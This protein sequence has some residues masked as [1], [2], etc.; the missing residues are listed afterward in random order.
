MKR[1]SDRLEALERR[2][3]GGDTFVAWLDLDEPRYSIDGELVT[4]AEWEARLPRANVVI[5]VEFVD[6]EGWRNA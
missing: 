5:R 2:T 1:L 4:L 3:G 6:G